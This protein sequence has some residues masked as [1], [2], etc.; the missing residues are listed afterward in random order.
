M[1]AKV[2]I[3]LVLAALAVGLGAQVSHGSGPERSY[4]V[5]PN[6]TLWTI[7]ARTYA[8][9]AREGVWRLQERNGLHSATLRPGQVITLPG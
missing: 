2:L 1:F 9:D 8:G 4:V 7:A 5:K 6:D 3:V